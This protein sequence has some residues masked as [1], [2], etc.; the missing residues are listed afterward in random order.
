[1]AKVGLDIS[2]QPIRQP[3][4]FTKEELAS[5]GGRREG[6]SDVMV[7]SGGRHVAEY[8]D[9]EWYEVDPVT[10]EVDFS[11]RADVG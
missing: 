5:P 3:R 10:N 1:M 7:L 9:G 2:G 6:P 8:G 4:Q 11:K